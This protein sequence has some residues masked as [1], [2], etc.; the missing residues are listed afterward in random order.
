MEI[1]PFQ[2]SDRVLDIGCGDGKFTARFSS[3]V[4]YVLGVDSSPAM[5][6]TAK[7][8]EYGGAKTDFRV[9]DCKYLG[10]EASIMNHNWDKM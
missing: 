7:T 2:A 6:E 10:K 9:M 8:L 5:I 3:K 1:I 4:D